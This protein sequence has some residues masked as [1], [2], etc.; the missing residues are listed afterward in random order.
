MLNSFNFYIIIEIEKLLIHPFLTLQCLHK[1]N[2]DSL[3]LIIKAVC[4]MNKCCA[5]IPALNAIL[6]SLFC[7]AFSLSCAESY[8]CSLYVAR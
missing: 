2:G 4:Y 1:Y 6:F 7:C 3:C 8:R 5:F